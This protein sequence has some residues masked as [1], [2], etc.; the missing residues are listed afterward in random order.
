MALSSESPIQLHIDASLSK[1]TISLS[2]FL[3][4]YPQYTNLV[5]SAFIF[6][7]RETQPPKLAHP[8]RLLILQR[9][10]HERAF[11]NLWEIPGGSSDADDPTILHSLAREIFEETGLKMTH[12][13]GQMGNVVEFRTGWGPR[14][15]I[16]A[17]LC[18]EIEV[19]EMEGCDRQNLP[20][21]GQYRL[22]IEEGS[23][24]GGDEPLNGS[25]ADVREIV[26]TIDPKEHQKHA[27]ATLDDIRARKY[28]ITTLEQQELILA[29]FQT[30]DAATG[31]G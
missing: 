13:I 21:A 27:W 8:A 7:T 28:N 24:K 9:A 16:W 23:Q 11:P 3:R 31:H 26:V 6:D 4:A 14:Q 17:K 20:A 5:V 18:F 10:A 1:Y 2:Q 15:K 12:V 25:K 19:A 29:A 22:E 30:R